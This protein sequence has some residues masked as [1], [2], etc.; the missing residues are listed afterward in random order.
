MVAKVRA[1]LDAP[2]L[3]EGARN[4]RP[5][6]APRIE[7]KGIRFGHTKED[8]R[9]LEGLDLTLEAG[10]TTAIVGPSGAGKST[11]L[12]L[13]AGLHVPEAGSLRVDGVDVTELTA[14]SRRELTSAVFQHPYLFEGTLLENI[15]V[16]APGAEEGAVT[17]ALRLARVEEIVARLPD[18]GAHRVGEAGSALSGGERQRVTIARALLKPAPILLVDEATSALDTENEQAISRALS[19]DPIPR[20]RV[21]VAHRLSSIRHADRVIF[22]EDGQIVEDGSVEALLAREGRFA[23]FWR[24]QEAAA[25]WRM[26]AVSEAG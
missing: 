12:G 14:S 4:W 10:T 15:R 18:G 23:A 9:V 22:L 7:L 26:G 3:S 24:Q 21:I 5:E 6:A 13:L 25:T 2:R 17:E 20:T 11:L 1:V 8:R 16:G 19:A